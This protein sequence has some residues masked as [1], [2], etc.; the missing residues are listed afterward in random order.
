MPRRHEKQA[1]AKQAVVDAALKLFAD[2][3]F[4]D[5]SVEE[6]AAAAG[7]SRRTFFRYFPTKEDVVLDPRRLDRAW[8]LEAM[9]HRLP[10]EDD[11]ALVFRVMAELQRRAFRHVG[12][13]DNLVVHRLS[14]F[15]PELMARSWLLVEVSRDLLV[16]GL[17]GT[18]AVPSERLRA[19]IL[20]GACV[21]AVDA[22]M[23][24]WIEGGMEGSVAEALERGQEDLRD[25]GSGVTIG[26]AGDRL[27]PPSA[28]PVPGGA[29]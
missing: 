1:R 9:A 29:G 22:V 19:R 18:S 28:S 27:M 25:I 11:I 26:P 20:V 14:H 13:A 23:S 8:A 7:I 5:V 21:M 3:P 4:R 12:P 15:E 17:L 10:G 16:E 24:S 2:R 6:I